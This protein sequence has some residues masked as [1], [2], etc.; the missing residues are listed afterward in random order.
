ME[1]KT[2]HC[3]KYNACVGLS[4]GSSQGGGKA[5]GETAE[6]ERG[7]GQTE[8]DHCYV[9]RQGKGYAV[10]KLRTFYNIK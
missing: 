7:T 1:E 8:E 3:V 9:E 5:S 2:R 4:V 6:G 10:N